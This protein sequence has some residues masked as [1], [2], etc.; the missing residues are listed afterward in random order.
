MGSVP[1]APTDILDRLLDPV[2][3]CLTGDAARML[4]D[5]RADPETQRRID[6]LADRAND[7]LLTDDERGEYE[8]FISAAGLIAVLQAKARDALATGTA[9]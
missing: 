5:L 6:Y 8:A 3:R 1:N 9:A 4:V 2:G 7:G